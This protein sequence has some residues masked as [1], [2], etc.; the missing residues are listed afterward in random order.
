MQPYANVSGKSNVAAYEV[1][2]DWIKVRFKDGRT[3]LYTEASAG[4]GHIYQMKQLAQ[5]GF[6][7]NGYITRQVRYGYASK[8]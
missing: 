1:G 8:G 5:N 2:D 3:Y 6:G 7:L 4:A